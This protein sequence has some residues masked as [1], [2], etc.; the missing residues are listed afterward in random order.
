VLGESQQ[1]HEPMPNQV[2]VLRFAV[3]CHGSEGLAR[4]GQSQQP[5]GLAELGGQ[6]GQMGRPFLPT[7]PERAF[8]DRD[9]QVLLPDLLFCGGEEV[10]VPGV[11]HRMVPR[12]RVILAMKSE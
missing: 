6:S 9:R 12:L 3:P 2:A 4:L 7:D 8:H 1:F 5:L 10:L 11:H